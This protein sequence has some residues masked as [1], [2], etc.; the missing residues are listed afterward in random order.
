MDCVKNIS[1]LIYKDLV[2]NYNYG[3]YWS[4][5][6]SLDSCVNKKRENTV[7]IDIGHIKVLIYF[8]N[9]FRNPVTMAIKE[10]KNTDWWKSLWVDLCE[11]QLEESD[12]FANDFYNKLESYNYCT[13]RELCVVCTKRHIHHSINKKIYFD[14]FTPCYN[15]GSLVYLV[16]GP[17][18]NQIEQYSSEDK[19]DNGNLFELLN[20]VAED[21]LRNLVITRTESVC[22]FFIK[23]V[24]MI[25]SQL[26]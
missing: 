2:K 21:V 9:P 3:K 1:E 16:M 25:F 19:Y 23:L 26:P 5:Y 17:E 18:D 12:R 24:N 7:E 4:V 22:Y 6:T 15:D 8:S 20:A 11:N 13:N 14:Y 10:T